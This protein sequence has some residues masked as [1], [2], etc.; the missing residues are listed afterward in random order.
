MGLL[1][2]TFKRRTLFFL[3]LLIKWGI[4]FSLDRSRIISFGVRLVFKEGDEEAFFT[5]WA[6]FLLKIS[7]TN[8]MA[9]SIQMIR[10][11]IKNN[12]R[13]MKTN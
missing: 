6:F 9:S 5:S 3:Y 11:A 12:K 4:P 7:H 10:V 13:I 8:F 2:P 1:A